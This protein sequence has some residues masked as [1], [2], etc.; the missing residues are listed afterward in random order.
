MVFSD[1]SRFCLGVHDGR[2]RVRRK[3]GEHRNIQF[4]VTRHVYQDCRN[5]GIER[6]NLLMGV[7]L[8]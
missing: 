7:D 5:Y 2:I 8:I 4:S 1:K 6:Y 3:S